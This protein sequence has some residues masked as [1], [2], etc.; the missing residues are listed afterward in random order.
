M[1]IIGSV[2]CCIAAA[3]FLTEYNIQHKKREKLR[4]SNARFEMEQET[5]A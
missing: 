1:G 5:K 2:A 4:E 3:L